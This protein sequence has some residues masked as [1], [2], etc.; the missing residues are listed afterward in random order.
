M[1]HLV[2]SMTMVFTN[3]VFDTPSDEEYTCLEIEDKQ[4]RSVVFAKDV[5]I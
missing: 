1:M 2:H 4:S 3:A 5:V